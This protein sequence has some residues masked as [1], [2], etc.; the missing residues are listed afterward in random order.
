M[1]VVGILEH[2]SCKLTACYYLT[3]QTE[4]NGQ[5]RDMVADEIVAAFFPEEIID[6][7]V[8]KENEGVAD[9]VD[10]EDRER[11]RVTV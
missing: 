4:R 7:I 8:G 9:G 11:S 10:L 5:F 1:K 2:A 6:T 3:L